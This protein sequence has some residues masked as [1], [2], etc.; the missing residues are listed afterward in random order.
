MDAKR[1]RK[2]GWS[3]QEIAHAKR[4]LDDAETK[5]HPEIAFGEHLRLWLLIAILLVGA[6]G[7]TIAVLPVLLFIDPLPALGVLLVLGGCFGALLGASLASLRIHHKHHH[8]GVS[9]LVFLLVVVV[10]LGFA[11]LEQ[12]YRMVPGAR[13]LDPVLA[14]VFFACG[15]VLPYIIDR[16]LHGPA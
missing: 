6:L 3:E 2:K 10:T 4:I 1:L 12:R 7:V 11:L 5:K 9:V 16:R 13:M 15:F 8:H 14:G